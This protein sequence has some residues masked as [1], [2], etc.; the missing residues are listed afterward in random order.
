MHEEDNEMKI[1]KLA[2]YFGVSRQAYYKAKKVNIDMTLSEDICLKLVKTE[3]RQQPKVGGK[4]LYHMLQ[5]DLNK[6]SYKISRDKLFKLLRDNGLLVIKKRR[7]TNTTNSESANPIYPN[8]LKS[9]RIT[10]VNEAFVA[11]ITYIRVKNGFVYLS[12]VSDY[13]SRK[14]MGYYVS[15]NLSLNGPLKALEMA[16]KN[17][18]IEDFSKT[19][20]HSDRGCQ[21]RS[22]E[23]TGYLKENGCKISMS[24]SGNPYDNAVMERIN[25][26]LKD[27]FLLGETYLDIDAVK[28]A[29]KQAVKTYNERRPH[30]S[31]NYK[32]PASVYENGLNKQ[33]A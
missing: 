6:L 21:Y 1:K 5:D 14:I 26:I 19:I 3:R 12:I 33:A 30:L 11:D 23:Y 13:K 7:Y 32:T 20:H 28:K 10:K 27:E 15:D 25:G 24:R 22:K 31:L 8:L 9:K 29:V 17:A 16:F 18:K 4:K 2:N